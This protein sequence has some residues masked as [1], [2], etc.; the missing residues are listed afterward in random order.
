MHLRRKR[1]VT[2]LPEDYTRVTNPERLRPLHDFSLQ[3]IARLSAEYVVAETEA[4]EIIPGIMRPFPSARPPITLTPNSSNEAP[5]SIAFTSFPGLIVRC[6]KFFNAP[7]PVCGC[8]HCAATA[9]SESERLRGIIES[10]VM[11]NFLEEVELPLFGEA[12]GRWRLGRMDGPYGMSGGGSPL[13]RARARELRRAGLKRVEWKPW[14]K[15]VTRP[16]TRALGI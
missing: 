15:P 3:L 1:V 9:E 14:S 11:G 2:Q 12:R 6:G 5:I 8:D 10:V 13:S 7:F 4:F 16:G